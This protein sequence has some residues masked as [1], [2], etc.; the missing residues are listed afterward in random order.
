MPGVG[1]EFGPI[2]VLSLDTNAVSTRPRQS[3]K[4]TSVKLA[5]L[6]R[7]RAF[8]VLSRPT[9]EAMFCTC[10]VGLKTCDQQF[11]SMQEALTILPGSF[12]TVTRSTTWQ[13]R[14]HTDKRMNIEGRNGPLTI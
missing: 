12:T 4:K 1:I 10:D 9:A 13:R 3:R 11:E 2:T 8:R 5:Y 14:T 6:K 7:S